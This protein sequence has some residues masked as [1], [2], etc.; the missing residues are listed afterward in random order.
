MKFSKKLTAAAAIVA[1]GFATN[2]AAETATDTIEVYAGLAPVLE[3]ICTDV[4][5]GVWRIPV[6]SSNGTTTIT[7]TDNAGATEYAVGG[8]S[9]GVAKSAAAEA[10]P[11]LGSCT[12]T[13]S[14]ATEGSETMG[15]SM[16]TTVT[17]ASVASGSLTDGSMIAAADNDYAGLD[18]ADT[19]AALEFELSFPGLTAVDENGAGSFKIAGVLTIPEDIVTANYGGYKQNGTITVT[20]NDDV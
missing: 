3:L 17:G 14:V 10:A 5:F 15:V 11:T 4:K 18:G 8:N 20:I 2:V 7:L 1:A 9:T 19:A 12:F 16:A 6:R 13:G